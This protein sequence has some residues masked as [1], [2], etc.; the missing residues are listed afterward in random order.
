MIRLRR[1]GFTLVE[2]MVALMVIAIALPA[3]LKVLYQQ[4]DGTAY[5]RDQTLGQWVASNKLAEVRIELA[6]SNQFFR[7][8][9]NG[10]TEMGEQDFFWW[11]AS[12]PTQVPDFYRLEISVARQ[13]QEKENPLYKLVGF[14]HATNVTGIA[15]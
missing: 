10:V 4:I 9:R 2:V 1:G 6:R 8:E 12:E 13:E 5:L 15:R 7:G 14:I 3:L 11:M